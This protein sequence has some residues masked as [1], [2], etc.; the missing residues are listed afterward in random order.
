MEALLL[1]LSTGT[2]ENQH[3]ESLQNAVGEIEASARTENGWI[4]RVSLTNEGK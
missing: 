1:G 2:S 3:I 4:V